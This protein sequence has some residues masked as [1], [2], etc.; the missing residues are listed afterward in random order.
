MAMNTRQHIK[1]D[2][3]LIPALP[4]ALEHDPHR[5][6]VQFAPDLLRGLCR[7]VHV[8][9]YRARMLQKVGN[10]SEA[11]QQFQEDVRASRVGCRFPSSLFRGYIL[12]GYGGSECNLITPFSASNSGSL[13]NSVAASRCA[14]TA[15]NASAKE[16]LCTAFTS[17]A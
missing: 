17:A 8:I 4:A 2:R 1:P 7:F 9:F 11:F 6:S 16:S 3:A 14:G 13:E 10:P 15:T 5:L 12:P